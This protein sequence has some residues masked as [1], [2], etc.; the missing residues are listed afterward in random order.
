MPYALGVLQTAASEDIDLDTGQVYDTLIGKI[1]PQALWSAVIGRY[2]DLIMDV[3]IF[4]IFLYFPFLGL[5]I[6]SFWVGSWVW[7]LSFGLTVWVSVWVSGFT[8]PG[9]WSLMG[10]LMDVCLQGFELY[11]WRVPTNGVIQSLTLTADQPD[12]DSDSSHSD[13]SHSDSSH[14]DSSHSDSSP[15]TTT[16]TTIWQ[17]LWEL[18][19]KVLAMPMLGG[20]KVFII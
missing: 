16:L 2:N 8:T 17:P 14:S 1:A 20:Q 13:S 7:D 5:R 6:V 18:L 19:S 15:L 11:R 3:S 4:L 10:Y 12:C 9:S